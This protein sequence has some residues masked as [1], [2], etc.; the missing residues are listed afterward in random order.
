MTL[1]PLRK[2]RDFVLLQ[3]GQTLSTIGSESVGIAYPLLVLAVTGSPA[4]AGVVGF[5]RI[6]PWA[7]FGFAAGVVA[8][9][10][11]RKRVMIVSDLIRIVAVL[12]LVV[13]LAAGHTSVVRRSRSSRSS[14]ARCT[15]SSTSPSSARCARSFPADSSPRRRQPSRRAIRR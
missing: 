3:V 6:V 13:A 1:V 2:N 7:L 15:C 10:L 5:A 11:N 8:D 4:Q 14:R 9:R 12:T